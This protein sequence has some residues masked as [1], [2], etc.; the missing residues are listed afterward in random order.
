VIVF[1]I[2]INIIGGW[3]VNGSAVGGAEIN[4]KIVFL[5]ERSAAH[6]EATYEVDILY[7]GTDGRIK[8]RFDVDT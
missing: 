7:I 3:L 1:D 4:L 8:K 5:T 2:A 6:A